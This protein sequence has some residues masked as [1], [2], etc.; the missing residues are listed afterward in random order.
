MGA[1]AAF[2][3]LA[4]T[5]LC[6]LEVHV[7][8]ALLLHEQTLAGYRMRCHCTS[9]LWR[10]TACAAIARADSGGIPQCPCVQSCTHSGTRVEPPVP[11][12]TLLGRLYDRRIP[13][14]H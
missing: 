9:R 1:V 5:A 13:R 8:H 12:A 2:V 4:A 3:M 14:E 11:N 6:T 10:D 7:S